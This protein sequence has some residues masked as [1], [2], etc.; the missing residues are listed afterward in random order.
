MTYFSAEKGGYPSR[1]VIDLIYKKRKRPEGSIPYDDGSLRLMSGYN[2]GAI[3]ST[4]SE[5]GSD[6]VV[7]GI[8]N[9]RERLNREKMPK[10]KPTGVVMRSESANRVCQSPGKWL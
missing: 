10:E 9:V 7:P 2:L 6:G 5:S 1:L 4:P 8:Q 3:R